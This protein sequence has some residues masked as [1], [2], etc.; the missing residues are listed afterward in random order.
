MDIIKIDDKDL[1]YPKRLLEIKDFPKE[2]YVIGNIDLL[3]SK[4]TV[5]I[6][7]S[8]K[9]SEYGR[10]VAFEFARKL[11]SSGI[12]IISGMALGIDAIS[13]NGA[14][15]EKG[16]MVHLVICDVQSSYAEKLLRILAERL[17]DAYEFHLFCDI[18]KLKGFSERAPSDILL[19][20]EE[21]SEEDRRRIPADK[22][23]LLTGIRDGPDCEE[24]PVFRYQSADR[25]IENI[26]S[27]RNEREDP[28]VKVRAELSGKKKSHVQTGMKG[29]IGVYSPV[30]RIGK[31]RFALRLGRQLAEK[32]EVLYLNMEGYA[33][34]SYY[35]PEDQEMDLG[36]LLYFMRQE[37][38]SPGIRISAMTGK[39]DGMDYIMPMKHE[40][41]L[42]NVKAE[43]WIRMLDMILEKCVYEVVILDLGDGI[44]GLYDILRKCARVY[45]LYIEEGAAA[46]KIEQYEQNLRSA[47]Y[48]DVLDRTVKKRAK[49][50]RTSE[51]KG[52]EDL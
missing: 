27:Q 30:H 35:F 17:P 12:C 38:S 25:I 15:E 36:D 3:K 37:N 6:V 13:H 49:R 2:L 39:M 19:I 14:I 9:C 40:Q 44:E 16:R 33:G 1:R 45:T 52:A 47:G 22:K 7:G 10:K 46:A 43:E 48:G 51:E 18:E 23:F 11:S 34:G 31:T 4:N 24:I 28:I 41:D 32:T 5:G 29:L 20:G 8:R 21:F 42:R 50:N 26:F